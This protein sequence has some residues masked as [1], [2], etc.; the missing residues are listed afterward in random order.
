MKRYRGE[1]HIP[2]RV[3]LLA[4]L[5]W[6]IVAR[7]EPA[8]VDVAPSSGLVFT[9]EYGQTFPQA[10]GPD[11]TLNQ[12]DMGNG[13]AVGD[14][15]NDGDLDILLLANWTHSNRLFRNNL[16][17]GAKTFTDVTSEAGLT[18]D[19][20][21]RVAHFADLDNDGWLD[22]I[23]VNDDDGT[24]A[25]PSSRVYRNNADG[26]FADVTDGSGFQPVGFLHCGATLADY[27]RD[28]LPDIYVTVWARKGTS[29]FISFL[30]ENRLYR[31][32]GGFVF[33]DVSVDVRL[34]GVAIDSFTP[35]LHDFNNDGWP[36]LFVAVDYAEDLFYWNN[37]GTF[38][39]AASTVNTLHTGNDM[40]AALA[41][42]DDDGDLDIYTT[43]ITDPGVPGFGYPTD[44]NCFYVNSAG[45]QGGAA[46]AD[47]AASRGVFDT[48][49]G[50]GVTFIDVE[51]DG[52]LDIM[53]AN[54]LDEFVA[55]LIPDSQI[56]NRPTVLLENDGSGHF[57]RNIAPGLQV[58][59]DSRAL[60]AFDYDRDG[61]EDVLIT[62]MDQPARL[63][64][65]VSANQGHWLNVRLIQGAG[66]LRDA[67]GATVSVRIGSVSKRREI[68]CGGSYLA[69]VPA[70]AHFGVGSAD[71]ID[72]LTVRW[73]DG[74]TTTYGSVTVD[75]FLT[76]SRIPGDCTPDGVIDGRDIHGF[77]MSL[78]ESADAPACSDF[79]GASNDVAERVQ[80]FVDALLQ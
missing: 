67:I 51:N 58:G 35:I 53:A 62:N 60:I 48:Y 1:R 32:L 44:G 27:D 34:A 68:L 65:N 7:G 54:G 16:E 4:V 71:I 18:H 5:S 73:P 25:M 77:V 36:D 26:T 29:P 42:F 2:A 10:I 49:W 39:N 78:L 31:N 70:E 72:E 55:W 28:G 9:C 64:E 12:R 6:P 11:A 59:E 20:L 14:Y 15:D 13:A 69:G 74:E 19:G 46:F 45:P 66:R 56:L 8:F 22:L 50:W 63:L 52:D 23:I 17:T 33:E 61:D 37:A 79:G 3:V 30:G 47:E 40:G 24:G 21:S 41:D 80:M 57:S 75:Q 43:N 76:I 38:V